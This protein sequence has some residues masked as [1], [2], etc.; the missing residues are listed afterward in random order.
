MM[1]VDIHPCRLSCRCLMSW[2]INIHGPHHGEWIHPTVSCWDVERRPGLGKENQIWILI[3]DNLTILYFVQCIANI[4]KLQKPCDACQSHRLSS[5]LA[6]QHIQDWLTQGYPR[7]MCLSL[8]QVWGRL[9]RHAALSGAAF[10]DASGGIRHTS[11]WHRDVAGKWGL[12]NQR[13]LFDSGHIP[14]Y[15]YPTWLSK[16]REVLANLKLMV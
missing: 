9:D 11:G 7:A 16:C 15:A 14:T 1:Y 6:Q 5:D 12:E 3:D 13:T 10:R 2:F 4:C 8:V